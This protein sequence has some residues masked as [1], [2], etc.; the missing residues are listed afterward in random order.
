MKASVILPVAVGLV[1]TFCYIFD[2]FKLSSVQAQDTLAKTVELKVTGMTCTGCAKNIQSVLSKKEGILE[3]EVKY[4]DGIA[5]V[6]F[7]AEKIS[8]K[9]IIETIEKAGYKAEKKNDQKERNKSSANHVKA[10]PVVKP[11]LL[12]RAPNNL[13]CSP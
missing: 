12:R 2:S 4:P 1:C 7:K 9:E 10:G 3:S 11:H 5:V 6:K 13:H 8:E